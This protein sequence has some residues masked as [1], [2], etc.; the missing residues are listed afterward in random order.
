MVYDEGFDVNVEEYS[1]FAFS[2]YSPNQNESKFFSGNKKNKWVS[3]CYSTLLGW[4][5]K[6]ES[7]GCFYGNKNNENSN[8]ITNGEVDNKM[9]VIENTVKSKDNSVFDFMRFRETNPN[10]S[11]NKLAI[12][13]FL[14]LL[15]AKFSSIYFIKQK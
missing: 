14:I 10:K 5:H 15:N 6:G 13:L 12:F 11:K 4:Y 7:W 8:L 3:R 9:I 2:K 1:F